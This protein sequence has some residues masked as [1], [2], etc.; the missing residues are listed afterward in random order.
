MK[1]RILALCTACLML[2][3]VLAGCGG[4]GN[5]TASGGNA[6][7]EN[8]IVI[9]GL[10]PLTGNV[11]VYGIATNNAV[12][13]AFDEINEAGG[14]LGKQVKYV[15]YDEKGDATEAVQ[16]FN[17]LVDNDKI[18]ALIGDV[19]SKPTQAVAQKAA[20][21]NMPM[22]TATATALNVTDAGENVFRVCFTDPFQGSLMAKYAEKLGAKTA[23]IIYDITDDYSQGLA[24]SFEE[25]AKESGI[26]IVAKEG[27]SSGDVDFQSQLTVIADSNPDVFYIPCYYEDVALIAVQAM[28]KGIDCT[29]LGGDGWDGVLE[30]IDESN[31]DALKDVYFCKGFTTDSDDEKI[32][33]FVKN[34]KE[35][36]DTDPVSFSALGYDAAYML[37]QAIE[38]AGST[39]ADAII[40]ALKNIQF[41][42]ITGSTVFD[43]H[44]DPIKNAFITTVKDGAYSLVEVFGEE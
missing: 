42:G 33:N 4:N 11:S 20:E 3:A 37:K 18:V 16:A 9:G 17:K 21:I 31:L 40:D 25:T 44:R 2:M 27:Y 13:M 5:S 26:E 8:T 24:D 1:K 39:D 36:Y 19:T 41:D 10:A 6:A 34:Y 23:A 14:I 7:D 12:Q 28:N 32:Q 22:I 29:L 30:Q 43:D 15:V 35:L 38:E